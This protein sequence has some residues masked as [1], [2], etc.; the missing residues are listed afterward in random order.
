VDEKE[1]EV[2][3]HAKMRLFIARLKAIQKYRE[4]FVV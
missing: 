2:S 1:E 3:D 4:I